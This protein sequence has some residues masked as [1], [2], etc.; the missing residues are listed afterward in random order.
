[1]ATTFGQKGGNHCKYLIIDAMDVAVRCFFTA[2]QYNLI[3]FFRVESKLRGRL[4]WV[5]FHAVD[6]LQPN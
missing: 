5:N 6:N 2:R 3:G 4:F 1:M